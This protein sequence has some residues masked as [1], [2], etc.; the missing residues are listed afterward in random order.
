MKDQ[1]KNEVDRHTK[2]TIIKANR[3]IASVK[4]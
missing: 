4:A 1:L 3:A 2:K